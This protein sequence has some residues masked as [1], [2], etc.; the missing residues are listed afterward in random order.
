MKA[1]RILPPTAIAL[2][3]RAA[4]TPIPAYDPL[5]RIKA[6]EQATSLVRAMYPFHFKPEEDYDASSK[7]KPS[8]Q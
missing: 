6:I 3:Q 2:L 5:A 1:I 7:A 8:R 4:C